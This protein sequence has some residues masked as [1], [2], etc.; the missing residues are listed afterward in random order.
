MSCPA[1]GA[2]RDGYPL[3]T[4]GMSSGADRLWLAWEAWA[5]DASCA[6]H[7]RVYDGRSGWSSIRHLTPR[8]GRAYWPAIVEACEQVWLSWCTPNAA[9]DGYD[10]YL[11]VY[12]SGQP[13][14]EA[15]IFQLNHQLPGNFHLYPHL[16]TNRQGEVWVA[17]TANTELEYYDLIR[18]PG[19]SDFAYIQDERSRRKRNIW[20][21]YGNAIALRLTIDNGQ[22]LRERPGASDEWGRWPRQVTATIRHCFSRNRACPHYWRGASHPTICSRQFAPPATR[23]PGARPR[24]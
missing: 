6:I 10:I 9:A 19:N 2:V 14:Q 3:H 8:S 12:T 17:W 21:K 11:G 22:L 18:W 23:E 13:H 24:A 16:Q 4:P 5:K 15:R 7:A 1:Y 20:W